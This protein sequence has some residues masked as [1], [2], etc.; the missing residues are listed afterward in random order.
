MERLCLEDWRD[1]AGIIEDTPTNVAYVLGCLNP[2][3][4]NS[5]HLVMG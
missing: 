1:F 4:P 3:Q 2:N 5:V